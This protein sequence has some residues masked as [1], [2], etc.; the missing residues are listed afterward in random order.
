MAIPKPSF[1]FGEELPRSFLAKEMP[2]MSLKTDYYVYVLFDE[3]GIPRYIGKGKK[4]RLETTIKLTRRNHMKNAFLKRTLEVLGDIPRVILRNNLTEVQALETEMTLIAAI[5]R[6]KDNTGPLTNISAGGDGMTSEEARQLA[7]SFTPMERWLVNK[8]ISN[9][10]RTH[11]SAEERSARA[12]RRQH[13]L[14]PK[15]RKAAAAKSASTRI[16]NS[17]PE[18]RSNAALKASLAVT[19]VRWINN[20]IINK[21]IGLDDLIPEG[22]IIGRI[23]N[24]YIVD[25]IKVSTKGTRWINNGSK[26]K[27]LKNGAELPS[28]WVLGRLCQKVQNNIFD[29]G[30]MHF[31]STVTD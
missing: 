14:G 28:G 12:Y 3:N 24:P 6:R 1:L 27:R 31:F 23:M 13:D 19:K 7:A 18:E 4:N 20:S 22:W 11:H 2:K 10:H 17:S 21:R 16:A 8:A 30:P 15:G 26:T 5:G 9:G 29:D 25:S